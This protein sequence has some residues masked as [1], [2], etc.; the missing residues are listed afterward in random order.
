MAEL[1]MNGSQQAMDPNKIAGSMANWAGAVVSLALVAGA[2]VWGYKLLVRDVTGIPV[3]RAIEGPM[4]EQPVDPGGSQA[5]H[6]GL[7]VNDV[8]AQGGAAAPADRLVLAPP[9]IDLAAEDAP[10]SLAS[11]PAEPITLPDP[12]VQT[13]PTAEVAA[14]DTTTQQAIVAPEALNNDQILSLVDQIVG[15]TQPLTETP[16]QAEP[17]IKIVGGGIGKSLRPKLRPAGLKANT[18]QAASSVQVASAAPTEVAPET[19]PAGTRLV[20][21]GAFASPEIARAEWDKLQAK[22]GD[23]LGDKQR[24]VQKAESGG[25]TFYRLRAQ[26]FADL[27]DARRL[28]S[29]LKAENAD[30]IPVVTR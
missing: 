19:I 30:C 9:P 6:Q 12:V 15:E 18:L 4:R 26:G 23:Y 8:A 21:L 13:A 25:R 28:C 10:V 3:V 22:F 16:P 24:V 29:A 17:T 5:A 14:I 20:Q 27:S 1:P 11:A 2:G 7:A